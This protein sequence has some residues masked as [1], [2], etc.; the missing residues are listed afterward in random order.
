MLANAIR[1][2]LSTTEI[3]D[4]PQDSRR[5]GVR[6]EDQ[7]ECENIM[8]TSVRDH[9]KMKRRTALLK[10]HP[11]KRL[12]LDTSSLKGIARFSE[13]VCHPECSVGRDEAVA[14]SDID[15]ALVI[16]KFAISRRQQMKIVEEIRSQGFTAYHPS[17]LSKSDPGYPHKML[18]LIHFHTYD[19]LQ[20]MYQKTG[21]LKPVI[22]SY[23]AGKRVDKD[24]VGRRCHRPRRGL[25]N[26]RK[27]LGLF[28]SDSFESGG[29]PHSS[30]GRFNRA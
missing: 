17:E 12:R 7:A 9:D 27:K 28:H 3:A 24:E 8:R 25:K 1:G 2:T 30:R 5:P 13:M 15:M 23:I 21:I 16:S 11:E 10:A 14:G 20:A 4:V 22:Q 18:E 29:F 26:R 6:T 19:E